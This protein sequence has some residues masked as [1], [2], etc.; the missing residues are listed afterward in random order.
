MTSTLWNRKKKQK[1]V[2]S[3]DAKWNAISIV[4]TK[5]FFLHFISF[6]VTVVVVV[7]VV[8][9]V[10]V[11]VRVSILEQLSKNIVL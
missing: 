5:L 9:D 7:A 1:N 4:Q 11:I 10:V 3:C 6:V 2:S 8:V